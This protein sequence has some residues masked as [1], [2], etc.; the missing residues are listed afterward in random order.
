MFPEFPPHLADPVK[1]LAT[2]TDAEILTSAVVEQ[3]G[4]ELWPD[5][6]ADPA[7]VVTLSAAVRHNMRALLDLFAGA[8]TVADISPPAGFAFT[9]LAAEM[10]I[11]VDQLEFA[12]WIGARRFW[13]EWSGTALTAVEAGE[14]TFEELIRVPTELMFQYLVRVNALVIARH[15][16]VCERIRTSQ[17]DKRR[18]LLT[19]ILDGRLCEPSTDVEN[20]LGYPFAG[21]H[22]ALA[23]EVTSRADAEQVVG[24]LIT[25]TG[26]RCSV[27]LLHGPGLWIGWLNLPTSAEID[28]PGQIAPVVTD[29][30]VAVS[31]GEPRRDF[32]GFRRSGHDTL[33]AAGMR[34]RFP[35][36]PP[37]LCFRDVRLEALMMTDEEAARL[38]IADELGELNDSDERS[39]RTRETLLEWLVTGSSSQCA[40]RM[41]VHENTIRLRVAHAEKLL[42]SDLRTRRAQLLAALRLRALLG[43]PPP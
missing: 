27:L 7:F 34:Q 11:P 21:T 5:K 6:C 38:F 33:V 40:A 19:Q 17:E 35:G 24:K 22:L 32:I 20:A 30:G 39:E 2:A 9:D 23:L 12:Y 16:A 36:L 42:P 13:R 18:A 31:I 28:I 26:A 15:A 41:N 14:G 3:I 43:D 1:T 8:S 25:A 4:R 10:S 37:V 29:I